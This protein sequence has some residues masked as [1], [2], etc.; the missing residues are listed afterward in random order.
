MRERAW[1]LYLVA[2]TPIVG[3]YLF[4]PALFNQ[5]PVFNAIGL[6]AVVAILVGVRLHRPSDTRPWFLFAAGQALF[7]SGDVIAYNYQRFFGRELPFPSIADVLY[8]GVFPVIVAG[9]LLLIRR[10]S[11]GRDRA[12][13]IDSVIIATGVGL[14]SWVFLIA[15][16]AHDGSLTTPA[17]LTSMAYPLM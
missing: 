14:L 13:L 1:W 17:R 5:G 7:V 2:M 10:R 16:Y 4:G 11:R 3:L 9:L 12:S 6:T 15:P 8:L